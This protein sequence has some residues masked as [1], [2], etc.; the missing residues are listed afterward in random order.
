[1]NIEQRQTKKTRLNSISKNF[2]C[3]G[4]DAARRQHC[5]NQGAQSTAPVPCQWQWMHQ[6]VQTS[7]KKKRHGCQ[8]RRHASWRAIFHRSLTK[9][10]NVGAIFENHCGKPDPVENAPAMTGAKSRL[11]HIQNCVEGIQTCHQCLHSFLT[12]NPR[13]QRTFNEPLARKS[14]QC[15]CLQALC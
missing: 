1:M 4:N 7:G 8:M 6:R 14:R 12:S 5:A 13:N 3:S 9:V 11:G 10:R 15:Q 2:K